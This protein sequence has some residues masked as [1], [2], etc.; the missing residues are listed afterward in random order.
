MRY[1]FLVAL[2]LL[3]A[4][5]C[6][7]A[8]LLVNGDFETG[9]LTG[10]TESDPSKIPMWIEARS[11]PAQVFSSFAPMSVYEILFDELGLI[12]RRRVGVA[13]AVKPKAGFS[14][15]WARTGRNEQGYPWISQTI[16]VPPG[17]YYLSASWD[18]IAEHQDHLD[19]PSYNTGG[20]FQVNTDNFC[21]SYILEEEHAQPADICRVTVWNGESRGRWVTKNITD[22][23]IETKTGYIEVRLWWWDHDHLPPI[24]YPKFSYTAFDNVSVSLRP[25]GN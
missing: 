3:L 14:V 22:F 25:A 10:W 23:P 11:V 19:D 21:N 1:A 12:Y 17:K 13:D 15:G 4:V 9:D 16:R 6:C 7:F 18:V 2:F 8:N 24:I 20:I 5:S